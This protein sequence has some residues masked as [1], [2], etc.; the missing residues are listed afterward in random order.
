MAGEAP[1]VIV[2]D[3]DPA[4]TTEVRRAMPVAGHRRL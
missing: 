4:K 3:I 1:G 2:A